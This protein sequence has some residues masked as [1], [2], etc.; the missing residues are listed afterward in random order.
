MGLSIDLSALDSLSSGNDLEKIQEIF[1]SI[2]VDLEEKL[3]SKP[4]ESDIKV[5]MNQDLDGENLNLKDPFEF[6]V[7]RV[8][9]DDR[10]KIQISISC[11]KFIP[12]LLLREC[13]KSFMNPASRKSETVQFVVYMMIESELENLNNITNWKKYLRSHS[14]K[15]QPYFTTNGDALIKFF[16]L[17]DPDTNENLMPFFFRL[18]NS[19]DPDLLDDTILNRLVIE[20]MN[21]TR[22]N[23]QNDEILETIKIL[24]K[25]FYS[26]KN[27]R[28]LLDYQDYFK[29]FKESGLITTDL[30]LR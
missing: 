4:H 22:L 25:I 16:K 17:E 7:K 30:S 21:L 1:N 29:Q 24:K 6:G 15:Y 28:A 8:K 10:S 9:E 23:L 2:M 19:L 13:Y 12:Q 20:F 27:Y 18:I 14:E 11:L 5:S 3:R 26:V